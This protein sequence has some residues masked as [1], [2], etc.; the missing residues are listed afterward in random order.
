VIFNLLKYRIS[1]ELA[2]TS[3]NSVS[4]LGVEGHTVAESHAFAPISKDHGKPFGNLSYWT[5]LDWTG[6]RLC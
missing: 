1:D 4:R 2:S 5:G 3:A 6:P